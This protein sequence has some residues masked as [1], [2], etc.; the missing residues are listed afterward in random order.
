MKLPNELWHQI[1]QCFAQ[2]DP[3]PEELRN[4]A[5]VSRQL[6]FVSLRTLWRKPH[7]G[8]PML[9][10]V[11]WRI[12]L[13]TLVS[14]IQGDALFPYHEY[15]SDVDE[16]WLHVGGE[17][18]IIDEADIQP[19][20]KSD[21]LHELAS[22]FPLFSTHQ[23]LSL[24]LRFGNLQRVSL[25]FMSHLIKILPWKHGLNKLQVLEIQTKVTDDFLCHIFDRVTAFNLASVKLTWASDIS[26]QSL[27]AIA[28][29]CPN[30]SSLVINVS[31]KSR[32]RVRATL[33][34]GFFW[35]TH[36]DPSR[37]ITDLGLEAFCTSPCRATLEKFH[38][39]HINTVSSGVF[40]K[41]LHLE[42]IKELTLTQC[43]GQGVTIDNMIQ[44]LTLK[45]ESGHPYSK[46]ELLRLRA[47]AG[48]DAAFEDRVIH[49]S[50][51]FEIPPLL[52]NLRR[53]ELID[54]DY[55]K[56]NDQG[57]SSYQICAG[58]P[59]WV[60]ELCE[61]FEAKFPGLKLLIEDSG[62]K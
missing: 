44:E 41:L 18:D 23:F 15:I 43:S 62:G 11:H 57:I 61:Q 42:R 16:L 27:Q 33:N 59:G 50:S 49:H 55:C 53:L 4:V 17:D 48:E 14:S 25:H 40:W 7:F 21:T 1:V 10:K 51:V 36:E 45:R 35:R 31:A 20:D 28:R 38:V 56:I 26:D 12:F 34:R 29:A 24:A 9:S 19:Q 3:R 39:Y 30:L 22:E 52:P 13:A 8:A 32:S 2:E 60:H 46:L 5:L 6:A 37:R 58:L 54:L 47:G